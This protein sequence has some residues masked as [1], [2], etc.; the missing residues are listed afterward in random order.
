MSELV[1]IEENEAYTMI[2]MD[3]GKANALSFAMFEAVNAA[4]D[5]AEAAGKVTIIAGRPGKFSAGFDLSVMGAG[6]DPMVKLLRMGVDLSVRLLS[7]STPVVL[8]VTGHALAMGA[9]LCLS[10]DYRV[11]M[12]G[13][14]KLGLNEVAIGMTLPWFGIELA[15]A[16]LAETHINDAVGLAHVY[17]P[18]SAV[19]VG[20]IDEA[21]EGEQ[22]I[23]RAVELATGYSALNMA[24]H[25]AT[26]ARIREPLMASLEEAVRRDFAAG[27]SAIAASN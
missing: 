12:K 2:T 26:K 1:T 21:V 13:N 9:L 14:Y 17:D 10:A 7:F 22:L 20:Y 6:G 3:D 11:G 16:R 27:T 8:A 23:S 4:L 5:T 18:G 25:K 15:R 19:T 24:A